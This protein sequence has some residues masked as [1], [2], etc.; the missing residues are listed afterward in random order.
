MANTGI[1][2][3]DYLTEP[4]TDVESEDESLFD[5]GPADGYFERRNHP[6]DR[7]VENSSV[8][9]EADAKA[10]EAGPQGSSSAA[11][12]SQLSSAASSPR[13]TW[14]MPVVDNVTE[15]PPPTYES[16][17][18][19]RAAHQFPQ[20]SNG[21]YSMSYGSIPS[22][23]NIGAPAAAQ[24]QSM[25]DDVQQTDEES[26]LLRRNEQKKVSPSRRLLCCKPIS[27]CNAV[28]ILAIVIL[29]LIVAGSTTE[30]TSGGSSPPKVPKIPPIPD[31]PDIP[32]HSSCDLTVQSHS[33]EFDFTDRRNFTFLEMME[34]SGYV[35][36]AIE[37]KIHILPATSS[38]QSDIRLRIFYATSDSWRV[39][40]SDVT[41]TDDSLNLQLPILEPVSEHAASSKPCM[42]VWIRIELRSGVVL[43][44]W[45]IATGNLDI[46]IDDGLFTRFGQEALSHIQLTGSSVFSAVRGSIAGYWS[47]R[48]T[49][50]ETISGSIRG[51]FALRDLL[52]V[53]SQSGSID[54]EVQPRPEDSKHPS[55]AEFTSHS[56]SGS[57]KVQFPTTG[58]IPIRNYRTRIETS[59]ASVH[60]QYILGSLFSYHTQ[61][62]SVNADLLPIITGTETSVLFTDTKS[63]SQTWAILPP[64]AYPGN[65]F[66]DSHLDHKFTS[67]SGSLKLVYPN[68]WE[69][70]IEGDTMSGSIDIRGK[71]VDIIHV[72]KKYWSSYKNI[73]AKK[74]EGHGRLKFKTMS[75]SVKIQAGDV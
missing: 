2:E 61:S 64:Y 69:G 26:G 37:G 32:S 22:N 43:E 36:G 24:P 38:Q 33:L 44:D 28:L 65:R 30:Y 45:E 9:A 15:A 10:R 60:G 12:P 4:E 41:R 35:G 29:V 14:T 62:G 63:A 40:S 52:S 27:L 42:G 7:F 54:I 55:P 31:M 49:E 18:R 21:V 17:S 5:E 70:W 16:I 56:S 51:S 50:I 73:I 47:S 48:R 58:D 25:S 68:E 6:Q 72:L 39:V 19:D 74:G 66:A 75:G 71:D 1:Y 11:A 13:S 46:Q 59:S 3:D 23:S 8:T 67:S 20:P 57:I 34:S 53:K